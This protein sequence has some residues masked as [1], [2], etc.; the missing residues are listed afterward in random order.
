MIADNVGDNVGDCAGMAA[1]LFET[2]AVTTV[3]VMLLGVL[4]FAAD[5]AREV[6]LYPLVLGAVAIIAS[7]VGALAVRTTTDKVE[8]ALYRGLI[9]SAVISAAAFYPITDWLMSD[10]L[11]LGI[12]SPGSA[13]FG[14]SV[15]ELWLCALIGLVV[16][17]G[18]FVITDYYTSTRFR[19]VK[20]ISQASIT[21]H[22]T[23]IIQG[24]AQGFQSAVA[25]GAA[26]RARDP[27]RQRARR[28]LRDRDRGD[29]PA[30][31][32]RPDRRPRRLRADHR[33]RR[34][35]RRDGGAA[36]GASATSPTRST[37][38]ATRPRR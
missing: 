14:A 38:S 6:A 35:D 27:R 25:A 13:L 30:L 19:P 1:D 15:T 28:D 22:A 4:T 18:L 10:P 16:T 7:I 3:A 23:N 37:R 9:I 31:A 33:Q 34:R 2:Y 32:L 21:G 17:G 8:G 24:L 36:R 11:S 29:G 5:F 12:E 20:T 26:D